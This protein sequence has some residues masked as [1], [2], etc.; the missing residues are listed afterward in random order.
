MRAV[1]ERTGDETLA[2]SV[3]SVVE[4][5]SSS[6]MMLHLLVVDVLFTMVV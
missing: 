2:L 6:L 1:V 4:W 5:M 3:E